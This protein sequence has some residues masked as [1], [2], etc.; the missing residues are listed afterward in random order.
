MLED[1]LPVRQ[2]LRY[3]ASS[4]KHR[5]PPV[6]ELLG[7]HLLQLLRVLRLQAKRVEANVPRRVSIP[8]LK[9]R[10]PLGVLGVLPADRGPEGLGN[11]D[12]EHE[13]LP[14]RLRD[15][16]KVGD[17]WP[18]DLGVEQEG[19]SL[20]LL[21]DEEAHEG[22]HRHAAVGELGLPEAPDLVVVGTLKEVQGVEELHGG[23][24]AGE[25]VGELWGGVGELNF[26]ILFSLKKKKKKI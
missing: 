12:G 15:L 11:S 21:A 3:E 8:E 24:G 25:A 13:E 19:A 4:G 9:V 22:Q 14:E 23:E 18:G 6:L 7:L 10:L 2:L 5:E 20:D 17:C 26:I 16:R 1:T